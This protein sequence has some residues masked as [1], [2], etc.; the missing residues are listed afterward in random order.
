MAIPEL[1]QQHI[2]QRDLTGLLEHLATLQLAA[3]ATQ[4][5]LIAVT[6]LCYRPV[7]PVSRLLD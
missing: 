5:Q 7:S 6:I 1:L 2:R 4:E 3:N